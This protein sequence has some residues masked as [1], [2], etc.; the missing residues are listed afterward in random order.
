ME[1]NVWS[2]GNNVVRQK[3]LGGLGIKDIALFSR[4]LRLRWLWYEWDSLQCPWKG[5]PVPCDQIDRKLFAACT[6]ITIGNG[7]TALFWH[8]R[9]LQGNAPKDIAP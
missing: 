2:T 8:D 9:W 6:E 7:Q 5:T 3:K 4:S 1:E